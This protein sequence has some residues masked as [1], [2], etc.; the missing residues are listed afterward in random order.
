M[1]KH[2]ITSTDLKLI[3][4]AKDILKQ[5]F[6]DGVYH[7]TV[8]CAVLCKDDEII[9]AVNCDTVHGSCAEFIAIGKAI[10]ESKRDFKTIVAVHELAP[11]HVVAPCGNCRQM[12]IDYAPDIQV[13][14][15]DEHQ[16]LIKVSIQD[17]LPLAWKKIEV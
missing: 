7:H 1:K 6:D 15:N 17:L 8:G 12:L 11:N 9:R 3:E 4:A 10:S 5:N 2:D 16:K 13:I 14:L